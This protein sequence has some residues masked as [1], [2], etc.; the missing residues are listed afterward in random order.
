VTEKGSNHLD[1]NFVYDILHDPPT[2]DSYNVK[3]VKKITK[4][5]RDFYIPFDMC[6]G[7]DRGHY[8][9]KP[10][11]FDICPCK[12][13]T[14]DGTTLAV[15]D[16][17]RSFARIKRKPNPKNTLIIPR[18]MIEFNYVHNLPFIFRAGKGNGFEIHHRNGKPY[19]DRLE[20]INIADAY[21]HKKIHGAHRT[22]ISSVKR[23]DKFLIEGSISR[24]GVR[25]QIE[26]DLLKLDDFIKEWPSS[27][28]L[29]IYIK[30][31][32]DAVF[33]FELYGEIPTSLVKRIE[34]HSIV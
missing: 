2:E 31:I 29:W 30:D 11:C 18:S 6:I 22:I 27:T 14:S 3:R 34:S 12:T 7:C 25:N 23:L 10:D 17:R 8:G 13:R 5:I 1:W 16:T 19:D 9:E 32:S 26:R 21:V 4:E 20:N 24:K 33:A 15:I 28:R